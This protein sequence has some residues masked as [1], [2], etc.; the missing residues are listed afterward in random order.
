MFDDKIVKNA[1]SMR[2]TTPLLSVVACAS[3]LLSAGCASA[4]PSAAQPPANSAQVTSL[5]K[6]QEEVGFSCELQ[7]HRLLSMCASSGFA[8][9]RGRSENNPGYAYLAVGTPDGMVQN[10]YPSNPNDY[11]QH[12]FKGVSAHVI[13]YM[14]V[15]SEKGEFFFL[16]E[17]D[18]DEPNGTGAGQW[19]PENLPDGW[20]INIK[21]KNHACSRV[22]SYSNDIA[23]GVTRASVW[24]NKQQE[25][26]DAEKAKAK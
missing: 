9:F 22:L 24:R 8:E 14:F 3:L 23:I 11:K 21:D 2:H 13:P 10:S 15:T 17:Q 26:G 19:T 1:I 5:C 7:D 4:P 16:T 20:S 25:Q 12:F 6:P 18:F